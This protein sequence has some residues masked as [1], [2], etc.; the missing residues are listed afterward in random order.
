MLEGHCRPPSLH[1]LLYVPCYLKGP[2]NS[3]ANS[4]IYMAAPL[5]AQKEPTIMSVPQCLRDTAF[6]LL[7]NLLTLFYY[8]DKLIC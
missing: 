1:S 7:F 8:T 5:Y 2:I 3:G 4:S 6:F